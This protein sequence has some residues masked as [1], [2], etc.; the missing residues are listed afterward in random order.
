MQ[1][2]RG[3]ATCLT[4]HVCACLDPSSYEASLSSLSHLSPWGRVIGEGV[5]AMKRDRFC[6]HLFLAVRLNTSAL[7]PAQDLMVIPGVETLGLF[8]LGG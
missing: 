8:G 5:H 1:A 2:V 3:L 6:P 7:A 4:K